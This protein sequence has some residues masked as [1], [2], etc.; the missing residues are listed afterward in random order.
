MP[1]G[2]ENVAECFRNGKYTI[3]VHGYEELDKD[4][5]TVNILETAIGYD[6][7]E[8]IE[9]YPTDPRGASCLV[10]G[11]PEPDIPIHVVV[12]ISNENPEVITAYRPSSSKFYPPEFRQRKR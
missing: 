4:S 7:P 1:L 12:G 8:I 3:T 9:D 10:L 6:S 11:W 2:I 5:I